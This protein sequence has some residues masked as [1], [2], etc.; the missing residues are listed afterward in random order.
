MNRKFWLWVLVLICFNYG[1]NYGLIMGFDILIG[2]K[3]CILNWIFFYFVV[4][5]ICDCNGCLK[6]VI[7]LLKLFYVIS[8]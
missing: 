3:L 2:F 8:N 4:C 7:N 5:V 1:I 6:I